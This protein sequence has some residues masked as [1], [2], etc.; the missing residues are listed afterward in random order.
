M[1]VAKNRGE[2]PREFITEE[3]DV[4]PEVGKGPLRERRLRRDCRDGWEFEG[5]EV[6]YGV[7]AEGGV[8]T[9]AL[10]YI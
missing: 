7:Q 9:Q 1:S 4:F 6:R 2:G 5:E 10:H 3:T 8:F